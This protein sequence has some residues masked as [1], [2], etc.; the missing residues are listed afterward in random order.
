MSIWDDVRWDYAA[1]RATVAELRRAAEVVRTT[2]ADLSHAAEQA[3]AAWRGEHRATFDESLK[4]RLDQADRLIDRL[5]AAAA[6]IERASTRAPDEQRSR[7][8]ERARERTRG[9]GKVPPIRG[10]R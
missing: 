6:C 9:S 3:T 8:R 10:P 2:V 4:R 1:A 5:L 7:E